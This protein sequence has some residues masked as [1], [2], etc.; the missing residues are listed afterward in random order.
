MKAVRLTLIVALAVVGSACAT[1]DLRW[2]HFG[3]DPKTPGKTIAMNL[4]SDCH[5][6]EGNPVSPNFPRLAGQQQDYLVKQLNEFQAHRRGDPLG[7]QYMWGLARDLTPEQVKQIAAYFSEQKPTPGVAGD[8]ALVSEGKQI[9]HHGVAD[10]G[11]PACA[12]CHGE[13]AQGSGET[14]RLADQWA[15]YVEA[16]LEVFHTEQRPAGVAMHAIV[17]SLT[18]R[19]IEALAAYLQAGAPG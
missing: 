4:C 5:G 7:S 17:T 11:V 3:A 16:Q 2:P 8:P 13:S 1:Q 10:K 6:L 15:H 19:D 14:P 9:F 12:T 18:P